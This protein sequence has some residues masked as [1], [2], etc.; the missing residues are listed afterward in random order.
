MIVASLSR[1]AL[2][3][4]VTVLA[5]PSLTRGGVSTRATSG[6]IPSSS[7]IVSCT[8]AGV[9]MPRPS[10]TVAEIVITWSVS[11]DVLSTAVIVRVSVA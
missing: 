10:V 2:A 1:G 8:G 11:S 3:R 7:T 9:R 4:A 6:D 5:S